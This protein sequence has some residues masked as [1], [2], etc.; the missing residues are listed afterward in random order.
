MV[1]LEVKDGRKATAHKTI[2][3]TVENFLHTD[4]EQLLEEHC[5][6]L[7]SDFA[8]FASGPTKNKLEWISEISGCRIKRGTRVSTCN[9]DQVLPGPPTLCTDGVQVSPGGCRGKYEIA[10]MLQTVLAASVH[11]QQPVSLIQDEVGGVPPAQDSGLCSTS[12]DK[13]DEHV[14]TLLVQNSLL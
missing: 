11:P 3:E 8:A 10:E 1:H 2:L 7:F 4:Q 6:L 14:C 5:H 9:A 13:K 12:V